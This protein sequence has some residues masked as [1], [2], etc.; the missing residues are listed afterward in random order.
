MG[1]HELVEETNVVLREKTQVLHL[2][3]QVGDALHAH[4]ECI[5]LVGLA[6]DAV[7]VEYIGIDHAATKD[8]HPT[9]VL[10][11]AATLTTTD[12]ARNVHLGTRLCEGEL[13]GTQTDFCVSTEHLTR[14]GEQHLLEVCERYVLVDVKTFHL[15][16]ETVRTG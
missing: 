14:K 1:C 13:A 10:A 4:T 5:S 2:I 12:V 6:V 8:F 3:F 16:E 9:G 11:E 7:R 15:M